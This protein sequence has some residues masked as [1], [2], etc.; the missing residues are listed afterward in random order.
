MSHF[1]QRNLCNVAAMV[2]I[3]MDLYILIIV[4]MHTSRILSF[5]HRFRAMLAVDKSVYSYGL[6]ALVNTECK[7]HYRHFPTYAVVPEVSAQVRF[8]NTYGQPV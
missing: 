1:M 7:V 4:I 5:S 2:V 6:C 8:Q 3:I